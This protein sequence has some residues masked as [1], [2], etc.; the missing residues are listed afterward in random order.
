MPNDIETIARENLSAALQPAAD[1]HGIDP[2]VALTDHGLTSLQKVL[3]L[4]RLCEDLSVDLAH[5]TERDVAEM[6]TLQDVVD[7]LSRYAGKAA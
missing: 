1:P 3:F 4:T 5:L 6:R 2:D 7:T